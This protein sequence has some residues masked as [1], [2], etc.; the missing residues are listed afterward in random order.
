MPTRK[1]TPAKTRL[2]SSTRLSAK[3]HAANRKR[4]RVSHAW[5]EQRRDELLRRTEL[6]LPTVKANKA[7]RSVRALL[8]PRYVRA[9]LAARLSLLQAADF[10]VKVLEMMPP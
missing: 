1:S 5:L 10:L 8:G 9:S 6:L 4:V 2:A 7:C 3:S